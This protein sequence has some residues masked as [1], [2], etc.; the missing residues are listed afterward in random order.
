MKSIFYWNQR[1][2]N[3][4]INQLNFK[5]WGQRL[6]AKVDNLQL[7]L[8]EDSSKV[9]PSQTPDFL[10]AHL[11]YQ[12]LLV[13]I[14]LA[15]DFVRLLFKRYHCV[16]TVIYGRTVEGFLSV[17]NRILTRMVTFN[18]TVERLFRNAVHRGFG[19]YL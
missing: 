10:H 1:K 5:E 7:R 18:V 17:L 6:Y 13:S 3:S 14:K 4:F 16:Y 15:R 9:P 12:R 8:T 11:L 2:I 19:T